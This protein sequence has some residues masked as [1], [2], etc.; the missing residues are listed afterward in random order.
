MRHQEER[1]GRNRSSDYPAARVDGYICGW[2]RLAVQTNLRRAQVEAGPENLHAGQIIGSR[3]EG[4]LRNKS[5]RNATDDTRAGIGTGNDHLS[6]LC[7]IRGVQR[8]RTQINDLDAAGARLHDKRLVGDRINGDASPQ[9]KAVRSAIRDGDTGRPYCPGRHR[10][11]SVA[12]PGYRIGDGDLVHRSTGSA[13]IISNDGIRVRLPSNSR[14]PWNFTGSVARNRERGATGLETDGRNGLIKLIENVDL[15]AGGVGVRERGG[16]TDG[17]D[18]DTLRGVG[19]A[20]ENEV[21][22]AK[23]NSTCP[24]GSS[25]PRHA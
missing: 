5:L 12:R 24:V 25:G 2:N 17:I 3:S 13:R 11:Q 10:N 20:A 1:V 21:R 6:D 7:R 9:G 19:K 4:S 22:F 15:L 18:G 14:R 8:T 23:E 16:V